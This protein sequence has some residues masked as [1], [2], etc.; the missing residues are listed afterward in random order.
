VIVDR[1]FSARRDPDR[2]VLEGFHPLKHALRF[3]AEVVEAVTPDPEA[4]GRLA[5]RLAPDITSLLEQLVTIVPPDVFGRLVPDSPDAAAAAI[6]VRPQVDVPALLRRA[7]RIVLLD[8][9]NHL[10]NIGAAIRVAAAA[11]ALGLLTTGDRDPWHATAIRGSA[12]LHFAITV[13]RVDDLPVTE[14][15][16]VA[17]DPHGEPL[18]PGIIPQD[19]VV[20]FGSERH[21]LTASLLERAGTHVAI[22]MREAV[23]SLNLATAVAVALYAG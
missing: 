20:A 23:S 5:D 8:H 19:A 10:G 14:R 1:F 11:G 22:P 2:A 13:A 17:F 15:P 18:R 6:A 16:V 3:G 12:G 21:G 7:G 4:L 9:P